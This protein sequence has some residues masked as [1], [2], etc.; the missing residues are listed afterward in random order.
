MCLRSAAIF[1][2]EGEGVCGRSGKRVSL[3]CPIVVCSPGR[4]APPFTQHTQKAD[5]AR[6]A[7][8]PRSRK[9][10]PFQAQSATRRCGQTF[11]AP[12]RL[13]L[14]RNDVS[15]TCSLMHLK[16]FVNIF[17]FSLR[18]SPLLP[19]QPVCAGIHEQSLVRTRRTAVSEAAMLTP[20]GE[21]TAMMAHFM[22]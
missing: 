7:R 11:R 10:V 19:A 6:R 2:G 16:V 1:G 15:K 9:I 4:A 21:E 12:G 5:P 14:R 17:G 8:L 3:G 18:S 22:Q 20:K 13:R